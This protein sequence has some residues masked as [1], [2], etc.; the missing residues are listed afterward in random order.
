ML[1]FE[2]TQPGRAASAQL[3]D[4]VAVRDIADVPGGAGDSKARAA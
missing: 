1:I 3:P 4:D 2:E